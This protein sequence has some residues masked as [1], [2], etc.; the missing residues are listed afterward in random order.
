MVV[1]GTTRGHIRFYDQDMCL[2]HW[3]KQSEMD[4]ITSLGFCVDGPADG[5]A[6]PADAEASM[7]WAASRTSFPAGETGSATNTHQGGP[8]TPRRGIP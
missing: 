2:L 7:S 6:N 5:P 1:I 8:R 3:Y 4:A